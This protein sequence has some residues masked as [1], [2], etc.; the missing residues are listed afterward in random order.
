MRIELTIEANRKPQT[1]NHSTT[2]LAS[3]MY[4]QYGIPCSV[5]LRV[6]RLIL[7]YIEIGSSTGGNLISARTTDLQGRYEA[8]SVKWP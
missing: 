3:T 6:P 2:V 7:E 4:V 5:I 1:L 8:F